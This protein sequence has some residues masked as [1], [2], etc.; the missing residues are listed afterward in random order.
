MNVEIEN[1]HI[2]DSFVCIR[3]VMKKKY[4]NSDEVDERY[5]EANFPVELVPDVLEECIEEGKVSIS[6][7]GDEQ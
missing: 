1:F 4:L 3:Y 2:Q 6:I 7:E 5:G